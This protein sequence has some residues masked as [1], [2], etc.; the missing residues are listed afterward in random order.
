MSILLNKYGTV[1]THGLCA[2]ISYSCCVS[3]N[4][5]E[6]EEFIGNDKILNGAS[7]SSSSPSSQGSHICLVDKASTLS[8]TSE[9]NV[10]HDEEDEEHE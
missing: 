4:V 8:H 5:E 9:A 2:S 6:T 3:N 10:Y 1:A 7:S